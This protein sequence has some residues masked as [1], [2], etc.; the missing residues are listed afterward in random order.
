MATKKTTKTFQAHCSRHGIDAKFYTASKSC[1]QCSQEARQ[2]YI[3][4]NLQRDEPT[5]YCKQCDEEKPFY[6]SNGTCK[7]CQK[8][9]VYATR[10]RNNET[11]VEG[12][13]NGIEH[14]SKNRK[15]GAAGG[16]CAM[17]END[18]AYFTAKRRRENEVE[19]AL[20]P[21]RALAMPTETDL[22]LVARYHETV[23]ETPASSHLLTLIE[24]RVSEM[25]HAQ[26][27]EPEARMHVEQYHIARA[28][29]GDAKPSEQVMR[30]ERHHERLCED[31]RNDLLQ[32]APASQP[33]S[34]PKTQPQ[35]PQQQQKQSS[36]LRPYVDA[37]KGQTRECF[38]PLFF[39][40]CINGGYAEAASDKMAF[41]TAENGRY[42]QPAL[43]H[44]KKRAQGGDDEHDDCTTEEQLDYED[45]L[46]TR[47]LSLLV[48]LGGPH[49]KD[50][51]V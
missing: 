51:P 46:Y 29:S 31:F 17:C 11:I 21:R 5:K 9:R 32:T 20:P 4:H 14:H 7:D 34:L 28:I 18:Y 8:R 25:A 42:F 3:Q 27:A 24:K 16:E 39:Q 26:I 40:F 1:V 50:M 35:P 49:A 47:A 37:F 33:V 23:K 43:E 12:C 2:R 13:P 48:R 10:Q 38:L 36:L 41:S 30:Y 19:K 45:K 22:R 15:R 6:P 44:I